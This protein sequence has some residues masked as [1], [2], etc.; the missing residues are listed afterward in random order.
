MPHRGKSIQIKHV[1]NLSSSLIQR[2]ND[3]WKPHA[4]EGSISGAPTSSDRAAKVRMLGTSRRVALERLGALKTIK[5]SSE[6]N[7]EPDKLKAYYERHVLKNS[8]GRL[9]QRR[10]DAFLG[11]CCVCNAEDA[12]VGPSTL[13]DGLYAIAGRWPEMDHCREQDIFSPGLLK[14]TARAAYTACLGMKH[15]SFKAY[16]PIRE[17][18]EKL[19]SNIDPSAHGRP[20]RDEDEF[21]F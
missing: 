8:T 11:L 16:E 3:A 19:L 7:L 15:S 1:L 6:D 14:H 2:N 12:S 4:I 21:D 10:L 18:I 9:S 17:Q 20:K 13:L 5:A